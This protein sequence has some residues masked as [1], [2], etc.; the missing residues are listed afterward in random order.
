M[1]A[2]GSLWAQA[3]G[4][5]LPILSMND[6]SAANP[7]EIPLRLAAATHDFGTGAKSTTF[8]INAD[9]LGPVVRVKS[10][11]TLPFAVENMLKDPV[12]LHWHGLHIPGNVD[13]V[14]VTAVDPDSQA[15][16]T[17]QPGDI[18][19]EIGWERV[20]RP[21]AAVDKLSKLRNLNS[22]PVQIYVQRGDMLFYETLRP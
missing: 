15:A 3:S 18:I 17:L 5:P 2:T 8:G 7:N 22:G 12:A 13:G 6:F 10:G 1:T 16:I 14:V 21:S 9:Y 20:T 4:K 11:Q 19:L